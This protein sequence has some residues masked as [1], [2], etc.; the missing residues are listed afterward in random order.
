MD[1]L[2]FTLP[3]YKQKSDFNSKLF[4][5][6]FSSLCLQCT[7]N[8]NIWYEIITTLLTFSFFVVELI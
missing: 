8:K 6:N 5:S 3:S 7:E 2:E 1:M 4:S